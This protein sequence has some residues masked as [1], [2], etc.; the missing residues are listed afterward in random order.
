MGLKQEKY[1][2]AQKR[3]NKGGSEKMTGKDYQNEFL[4]QIR[5]HRET[6]AHLAKYLTF[7]YMQECVPPEAILKTRA[8]FLTGCG[9]SYCAGIASKAVF[10]NIETSTST[11]MNP[12]TPTEAMRCVEYT[13]YYDTYRRFWLSGF[14]GATPLVC[15]VSISG[16]VRR[17]IEAMERANKFGSVTVAFTN[18]AESDFAKAAQHVVDLHVPEYV[19]APCVTSYQGSMFG[20][21]MMGLYSSYI[22]KQMPEDEAKRQREALLKYSDAYTDEFMDKL[23]EQAFELSKKWIDLGVDNMDFVGDGPDYATAFFG[24][25][26]MVESFGGLTTNDDSEDWQHI[27]YFIRTPEKVGTFIIANSTSPSYGRCLETIR[28]AVAIGRPTAVITDNKDIDVPD[29]CEVFVL[30]KPEYK[31]INPYL[32]HLPM[33]YVAAFTG[34]LKGIPDFRTDSELHLRDKEAARFTQ[35]KIVVVG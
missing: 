1:I 23:E 25:A 4:R 6:T 34:L 7:D 16:R 24:S 20:L 10:E 33:D 31:W 9:D 27:N 3:T 14:S 11:G 13:R 17:V 29:E 21:M 18:N 30:P 35:S 15:G 28:T 8:A 19:D 32:Q 12:G 26:K 5:V 22:R 2:S